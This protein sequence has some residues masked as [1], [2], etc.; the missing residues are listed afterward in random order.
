[1]TAD[2]NPVRLGPVRIGV[3]NHPCREPKNFFL[4]ALQSGEI[5]ALGHRDL[6]SLSPNFTSWGLAGPCK[7]LL[8]KRAVS[9]NSPN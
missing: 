4:K 1:M 5:G 7:D 6:P 8:L 3:M 9:N 2:F